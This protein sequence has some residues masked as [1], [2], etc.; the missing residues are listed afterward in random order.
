M[1][2]EELIILAML[3]V[4]WLYGIFN[5]M[6][7]I[8]HIAKIFPLVPPVKGKNMGNPKVAVLYCTYNDF[9]KEAFNALKNL[10]YPVD[11]YILDDS[12]DPNIRK[13]IDRQGVPV[14]RRANR[15]GWK[16]GALNNAISK[17]N[18][19][20]YVIVDS[21]EL[22][23]KDFV[24]KTLP[25]FKDNVAFVQANHICY[26]KNQ[27][28][29]TKLLGIGVDLHWSI[30]Q[31]Y[32]NTYGMVQIL[33]HGVMIKGDLLRKIGFPEIVA[34]D[35]ALT[36]EFSKRGYKGIFA[37]DVICGET[38]PP[39]FEAFR[40][41]HKKWAQG[42]IEILFKKVPS[43]LLSPKVTWYE[44]L[45]TLLP[46][47]SLPLVLIF[48]IFIALNLFIHPPFYSDPVVIL[49]TLITLISP[50]LMF[51]NYKASWKEKIITIVANTLAYGSLFN[52]SLFYSFKGLI[53]PTF[54][55]T[56]EKS[57]H[58]DI[59]LWFDPLAGIILNAF[60]FPN[61][62]GLY[63]L[64]VPILNHVFKER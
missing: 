23:P 34:E 58:K 27:N 41:R 11:I 1:K 64:S 47:L 18:A 15:K 37:Q 35:L 38:F 52:I 59:F 24:E 8:N 39:S 12:T 40:K 20:Y 3:L 62:L 61:L 4:F 51:L 25:Y 5:L 29:W 50:L 49:M 53:N 13:E 55:V 60:S 46:L 16:A 6:I 54:L 26:N 19:D 31:P 32:R 45:D 17:I 30:Y 9:N 22:L 2:F 44:K 63:L 10:N 43:F 42:T 28:L 33:G 48:P 14:I 57:K 56:G 36:M 21:D 7:N